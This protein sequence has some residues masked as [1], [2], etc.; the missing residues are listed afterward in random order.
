MGLLFLFCVVALV[1]L[2]CFKLR[3]RYGILSV[4]LGG[5]LVGGICIKG[6]CVKGICIRG[7][8]SKIKLMNF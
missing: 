2:N 7:I 6:I 3:Y 5:Y 8:G 1:F 4:F